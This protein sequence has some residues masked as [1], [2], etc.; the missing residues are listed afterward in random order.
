MM[1]SVIINALIV[2]FTIVAI[3]IHKRKTK[4]SILFRYFA[5]IS[6]VLCAVVSLTVFINCLTGT[7]P[8]VVS[9]LKYIGTVAV[10][11]TLVTVLVFLGPNIG[12]KKLLSGP[13]FFLHLACPVLAIGSYC[14]WDK[15]YMGFGKVFLGIVP[16]LLYGILYLYKAIISKA[17]EDFYGFNKTGKWP[18]SFILMTDGAFLI[19]VVLWAVSN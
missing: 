9:V 15:T 16:M 18:V 5:V 17:W 4:F 8:P 3:I 11:I 10:T 2:L 13:D 14:L 7:L 6:N 12:Y 19:S 1:P